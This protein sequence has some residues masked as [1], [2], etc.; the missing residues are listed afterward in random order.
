MCDALL[1]LYVITATLLINHEI[2]SAYW[3]EWDMFRLPGGI[4][5]FLW[6]HLPL[7]FLIL[8]GVILVAQ[9]TFTGLVL[10]LVLSLGGIVAF[11][12]NVTFIGM[13]R[14]EFRTAT[15]L[16]IL[17]AALLISLAQTGLTV[18]ILSQ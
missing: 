10:S 17:T 8:Y 14:P 5:G 3:R 16:M 2:D 15:S 1:W 6:I 9:R 7:I 11:V 12:V 13:G 18:Y 4:A